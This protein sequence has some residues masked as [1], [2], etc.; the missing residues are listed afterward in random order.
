MHTARQWVGRAIRTLFPGP[1]P[2]N[3]ILDSYATRAPHP[4]NALDI[5]PG[6]WASALPGEHAGLKAGRAQLFEDTR[7]VWALDRLGG[8]AGKTVLELGPLEAGHTYMLD[9][10]GAASVLAIEG[11]T[12]AYLKCLVV[13]ELLGLPSSRFVCG[14]FTEYLRTATDR[15]DMVV[16]SGVLYHMANPVEVLERCCAISDSLY[17]WT[18]YYDAA[19]LGASAA[20]AHRVVAPQASSHAGFAHELYRHEYGQALNLQGFCGGSR[21]FANWLTRDT[22][23]AA[24]RHFGMAHIEIAFEEPGHANGP[25]FAL[26]ARRGPD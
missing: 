13:K 8:V 6:E 23:V 4:Q 3:N 18:H 1:P 25:A 17:L 26:V 22:I 15:F 10:A 21:P 11:N 16:A 5:F 20:T 14:D 24:L 7:L 9:R 2:S 12:R 19:V